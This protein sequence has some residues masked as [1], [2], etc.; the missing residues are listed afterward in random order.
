[1]RKNSLTPS[2]A[3]RA[4]MVEARRAERLSA[5]RWEGISPFGQTRRLRA[6]FEAEALVEPSRVPQRR[7][8]PTASAAGPARRSKT[9]RY[10]GRPARGVRGDAR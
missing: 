1:M 6:A 5:T 8:A 4:E 7:P 10:G 2:A 3:G 9:T